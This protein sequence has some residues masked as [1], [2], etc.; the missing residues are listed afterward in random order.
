LIAYFKR[1]FGSSPIEESKRVR[2]MFGLN[3]AANERPTVIDSVH[4]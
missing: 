2:E 3:L 4:P 1:F